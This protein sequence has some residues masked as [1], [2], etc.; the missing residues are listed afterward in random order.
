MVRVRVV[1]GLRLAL[2]LGLDLGVLEDIGVSMSQFLLVPP[3]R[4]QLS[5]AEPQTPKKW[6]SLGLGLGI[7]LA[8]GLRVS[9]GLWGFHVPVPLDGPT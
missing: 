4:G 5:L 3:Q 7:V 6:E 2:G 8:L 1:L 9:G